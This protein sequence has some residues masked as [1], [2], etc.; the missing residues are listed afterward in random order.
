MKKLRNN[1]LY[2][3]ERRIISTFFFITNAHSDK[4]LKSG[5]LSGEW[6]INTKFKVSNYENILPLHGLAHFALVE[7]VNGIVYI[8][9]G[10]LYP[11]NLRQGKIYVYDS[12]NDYGYVVFW[13]MCK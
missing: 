13:R 3:E 2:E 11:T 1:S 9:G 12:V 7:L 6:E 4:L 10:E 5:F 8:I